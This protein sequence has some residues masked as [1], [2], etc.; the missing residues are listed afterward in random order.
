M[1]ESYPL[2]RVRADTQTKRVDVLFEEAFLILDA[3][4]PYN[5][6]SWSVKIQGLDIDSANFLDSCFY[7]GEKRVSLYMETPGGKSLE[8]EA[9]ISAVAVGPHSHVTIEGI[10]ALNGYEAL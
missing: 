7:Y 6:K 9:F 3:P 1:P 10:N 5:L 2:H 4:G 8:G